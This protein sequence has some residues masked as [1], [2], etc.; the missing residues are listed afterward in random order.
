MTDKEIE[1]SGLFSS[2]SY[3][4]RVIKSQILEWYKGLSEEQKS[5]ID[6]IKDEQQQ[7]AIYQKNLDDYHERNFYD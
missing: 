7:G 4:N 1:E 3:L 6:V 2:C 5:F